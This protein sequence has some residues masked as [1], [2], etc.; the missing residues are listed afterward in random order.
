MGPSMVEI[1]RDA[2]AIAYLLLLVCMV[3]L[4]VAAGLTVASVVTRRVPAALWWALPALLIALGELGTA[5]GVR[6]VIEAIP[7]ATEELQPLLRFAGEGSAR[8]ARALGYGMAALTLSL[9]ALGAA[10]GGAV[11]VAAPRWT[12]GGAAAALGLGLV[13]LGGV[14]AWGALARSPTPGL[15]GVLLVGALAMALVSLRHSEE[16]EAATQQVAARARVGWL[17]LGAL[18][19]VVLA[20]HNNN[21]HSL[22]KYL[23]SAIPDIRAQLMGQIM[24]AEWLLLR[25]G[26]AALVGAALA[27]LAGVAA[28]AKAGVEPVARA[29]LGRQALVGAGVCAAVLIIP[30]VA[31][32]LSWFALSTLDAP[33]LEEMVKDELR[34]GRAPSDERAP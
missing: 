20:A 5:L 12:P 33:T 2:G 7:H 3:S 19:A 14:V 32:A 9:S 6:E 4:L 1:F 30:W 16:G 26:V 34:R 13:T 27:S 31:A 17:W 22:I 10:L 29:L 21:L 15:D 8:S 24:H 28:L 11:K 18:L 23:Q 25:Q